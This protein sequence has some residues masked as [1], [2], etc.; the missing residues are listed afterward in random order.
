MDTIFWRDATVLGCVFTLVFA[1]GVACVQTHEPASGV[2][3]DENRPLPLFIL[4]ACVMR[5]ACGSREST[6]ELEVAI[7]CIQHDA[8]ER[9]VPLDRR[10][11]TPLRFAASFQTLV[12]V[13]V[14]AIIP[15]LNYSPLFMFDLVI[16]GGSAA[17]ASAAIYAA[18]RKLNLALISTDFGGEV[19]T[20][21]EI[22]N[23]PGFIHTDGI[24]LAEKFRAHVKANNV[25][26]ELGVR[27]ESIIKHAEGNIEVV[28]K[29][30]EQEV[31]Y[32]AKSIIIATGVH[33]R[34]LNVPG[35]KELYGKGVT[36]CTTCDG[37][38]FKGKKVVTVGGGNS[39]LESALMLAEIGTHVSVINKNPKF[40]GEQVL[41]DKVT[42]HPKIDIVY[43]SLTKRI[44]GEQRVERIVITE[45]AS[46]ETPFGGSDAE[47]IIDTQGVF[48]HIGLTPN[49]SFVPA[50]IKKNKMGEIEITQKCETS[51]SGIYAAGDV[52]HIPYKQI[53]VACGQGIVAA[54]AATDY[55]NR[56]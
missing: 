47:K 12:F 6:R 17:G 43:N 34:H 28:G 24:E 33:P 26:P 4:I 39:A 29:K 37:P 20:S 41:I 13:R 2:V 49:S 35:E 22:E 54:L 36:Y 30:G 14:V 42:A 50:E 18:R 32:E 9:G 48:I 38:L 23:Y 21:G 3:G 1:G 10:L 44:E 46:A 15:L 31:R 45:S 25:E 40:K 7:V 11:R 56:L 53:A 52:T 27:I 19:A 5:C 16:I 8:L 55:I 51:V